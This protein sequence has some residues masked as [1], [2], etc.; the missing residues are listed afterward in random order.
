MQEEAIKQ[1]G[2]AGRVWEAAYAI[3]TYIENSSEWEFDPTFLK[4]DSVPKPWT[5]VELGSGTGITSLAIMDALLSKSKDPDL[6]HHVFVTDLPEVCPLL[7]KTVQDFRK[8]NELAS[9]SS[10]KLFVQPLTWGQ[11]ADVDKLY[12]ILEQDNRTLS[13]IVCSD[14][15]YFPFLLAPLLR[16]LILLTSHPSSSPSITISYKIRSLSKETPFWNAFGLWFDYT[17]VLARHGDNEQWSRFGSDWA[18][19]IYVF[20]AYRRPESLQWSLPADDEALLGG[21]TAN[22]TDMRKTDEAFETLLLM[23]VGDG[24]DI[25]GL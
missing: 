20:V 8:S 16:T 7:E 1:F 3:N 2:I 13:H 10:D 23:E 15:V 4:V 12:Q 21:V 22:G 14:L 6:Q 19:G 11:A 17:P 24:A 25:N 9:K 5:F 18:D